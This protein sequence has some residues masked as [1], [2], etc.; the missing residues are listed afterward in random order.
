MPVEDKFKFISRVKASPWIQTTYIPDRWL[1]RTWRYNLWRNKQGHPQPLSVHVH[2]YCPYPN[3]HLRTWSQC[4]VCDPKH[5]S[6]FDMRKKCCAC[7]QGMSSIHTLNEPQVSWPWLAQNVFFARWNVPRLCFQKQ[8]Q[9]AREL[10]HSSNDDVMET[11]LLCYETYT[12]LVGPY[13][14]SIPSTRNV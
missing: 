8:T 5:R 11:Y 9:T 7:F 13:C 10:G 14:F 12:I 3:T 6:R 2:T 4:V 1:S